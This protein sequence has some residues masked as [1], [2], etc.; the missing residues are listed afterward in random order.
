[1][2]RIGPEGARH[3][4]NALKM[5]PVEQ[6]LSSTNLDFY[7]T[8][9]LTTLYLA[10]NSIE[11][12][13][14]RYLADSLLSN[15]VRKQECYRSMPCFFNVDAYNTVSCLERNWWQSRRVFCECFAIEYR[16]FI[17]KLLST[18]IGSLLSID[19]SN[20][21]SLIEQHLWRGNSRF[22]WGSTNQHC[23]INPLVMHCRTSMNSILQRHSQ[24]WIFRRTLLILHQYSMHQIYCRTFAKD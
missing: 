11:T 1:M 8:Q 12:E 2:N 13:G 19:T 3:I 20:T 6:W 7:L 16:E 18:F 5:N 10:R 15:S 22:T 4:A 9:T 24:C 14:A 17:L 21:G 23:K